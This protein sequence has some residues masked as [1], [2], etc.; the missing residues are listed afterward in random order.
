MAHLTPVQRAQLEVLKKTGHNQTEIAESIG[1]SQP[2]VS[3][4]LSRNGKQHRYGSA[5]AQ[6]RASE[7]RRKAYAK[8]VHWHDDDEF[9]QY[10]ETELVDGKS[11][12]QI[13]G[14]RRRAQQTTVSHQTIYT[15]VKQDRKTGGT[16]YRHLRYR[17]KKYKWRGFTKDNTKI[18]NRRDIATR[19][20]AVTTKEHCGDWESD[21]VVSPRNGTG[22]VATFAERKT[23]LFRA[24]LVRDKSAD[25]MVRAS[26][27]ALG[28]LPR[29][30]RRTMTHDNGREIS[31]HE[32]IT[33]KLGI[34]IYC[35]R[36][37]HSSDRGLNEWMNR[38]L[39]RFFPKGTDFSQKTQADIDAAVDWLNNCPRKI[40]GYR[41]P[42]EVF[43]EQSRSMHFTL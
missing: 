21:L 39:R 37:Y 2:T 8:R 42:N 4:E 30:L 9:K 16:L 13:A 18:P 14:R 7:R 35:A 17:G 43:A 36:P 23:L 29:G 26:T 5:K 31:K 20:E 19:P 25:E 22:A 3:R 27:D 24:V 41:T 28:R 32:E 6:Q 10:V 34:V 12:E 15:Y 40:L 1:C 38:E 11:P 33:R